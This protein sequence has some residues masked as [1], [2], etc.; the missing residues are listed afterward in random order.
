MSLI[1]GIGNIGLRHIQGLSKIKKLILPLDKFNSYQKKYEN[2]L[3][4]IKN[5][6]NV[7]YLE[8]F[9]K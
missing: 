1:I 3:N 4:E 5:F 6:N 2:E 8:N 7:Y 9:D